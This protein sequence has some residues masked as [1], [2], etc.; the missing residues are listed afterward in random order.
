MN[1]G[2]HNRVRV[3]MQEELCN[4]GAD[5]RATATGAAAVASIDGATRLFHRAHI[6]GI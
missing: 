2:M 1:R 4:G 5:R 6:T 3:R